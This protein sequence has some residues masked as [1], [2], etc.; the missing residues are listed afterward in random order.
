MQNG[1]RAR[2]GEVAG[3][4]EISR[5]GAWR[6]ADRLASS[7]SEA[8][9]VNQGLYKKERAIRLSLTRVSV[10][11]SSSHTRLTKFGDSSHFGLTQDKSV[12]QSSH[13]LQ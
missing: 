6:L 5:R 10:S 4:A 8:L 7:E 13:E 9:A 12:S 1:Y 3:A 2:C 11:L